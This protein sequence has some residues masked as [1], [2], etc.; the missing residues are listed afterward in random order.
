MINMSDNTKISNMVC[1]MSERS[2]TEIKHER[3][4]D[5]VIFAPFKPYTW[6]RLALL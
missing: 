3:R 6:Q 2:I 4:E 5:S 1:H